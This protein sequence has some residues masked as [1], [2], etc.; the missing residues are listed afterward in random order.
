MLD[1][2]TLLLSATKNGHSDIFTLNLENEKVQQITNDVYS[3]IDP[4]YV[5]LPGKNGIMFASN[6]PSGDA[7]GGDSSIPSHYRYNI[8]FVNNANA[9]A[10]LNQITQLSNC[11]S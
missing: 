2:R 3:D 5:A 10:E 11:T 9:K 8:F 7:R 4:S 6:R 1:S